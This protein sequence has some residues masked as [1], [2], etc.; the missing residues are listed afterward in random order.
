M[1]SSP[2]LINDYK[3]ELTTQPDEVTMRQ[4]YVDHQTLTRLAGAVPAGSN[5]D[6]D[7]REFLDRVRKEVESLMPDHRR[8]ITMYYFE[9]LEIGQIADEI[10]LPPDNIRRLIHEGLMILK[11]RLADI[12]YQRWPRRLK[13][14]SKCKICSHPDRAL[15]EKI[16]KARKPSDSWG[17]TNRQIKQKLGCSFNPPAVIIS[18][19]KY[20][21][22]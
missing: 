22:K 3:R 16:V 12:V 14:I 19:M 5:P 1:I 20:H 2:A 21:I 15:I 6:D 7:T 11:N 10:S 13:K 9:C 17:K 8:V 4:I 18:H